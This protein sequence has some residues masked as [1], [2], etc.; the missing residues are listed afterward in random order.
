MSEV[1]VSENSV[2]Q[3]EENVIDEKEEWNE[4][5]RRRYRLRRPVPCRPSGAAPQCDRRGHHPGKGRDDQPAEIADCRCGNR[6]LS[7]G[8]DA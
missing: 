2:F 1:R 7:G 8:E 4:N 6:S 5:H 3:K